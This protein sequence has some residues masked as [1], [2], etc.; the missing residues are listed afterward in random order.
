MELFDELYK[1]FLDIDGDGKTIV[2]EDMMIYR[3]A[4][5]LNA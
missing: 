2:M 4:D 1:L 3:A 5:E